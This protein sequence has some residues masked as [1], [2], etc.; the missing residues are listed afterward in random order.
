MIR[1]KSAFDKTFRSG[2]LNLLTLQIKD[3]K[4][5]KRYRKQRADSFAKMYK[6]FIVLS[7]VWISLTVISLLTE[8]NNIQ[9]YRV[10]TAV[11][12]LII[13]LAWAL[14]SKYCKHFLP[15]IIF[16]T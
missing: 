16:V 4:I 1:I 3:P 10:Y 12:M 13:H 7:V 8:R 14:V 9:F 15:Q 2:E 5:N 11:Q 6:A